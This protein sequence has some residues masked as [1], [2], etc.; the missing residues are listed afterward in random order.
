MSLGYTKNRRQENF[1]TIIV[2]CFY[3]MLQV[4]SRKILRFAMR[5]M[6]ILFLGMGSGL[7]RGRFKTN[8][9]LIKS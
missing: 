8:F 1:Y 2:G 4:D 5:V 7:G 6:G 9:H 3:E